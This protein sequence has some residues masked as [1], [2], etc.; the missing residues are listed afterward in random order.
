MQRTLDDIYSQFTHK[1]AQGRKMDYDKLEKLARGRVYTGAMATKLGLVD[2]LGTL[3]D[4]VKYAA[5]G[6]RPA[7]KTKRSNAGSCRP[8]SARL[9]SIFGSNDSDADS[10]M[11]ITK[12]LAQTLGQLSP[13]LAEQLRSAWIINLLAREPRLTLMPFQIRVR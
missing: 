4:A 2:E 11:Q 10:S 8:R 3:D 1:A 7:A 6:R 12:A 5:Q 13:E 9:E